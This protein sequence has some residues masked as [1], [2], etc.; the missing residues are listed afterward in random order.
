MLSREYLLVAVIALGKLLSGAELPASVTLTRGALNGIRIGPVAVYADAAGQSAAPEYILFTHARRDAVNA[1]SGAVQ[2]GAAAV[3]PAL[4]RTQFEN[5]SSFWEPFEKARF[6]DYAQPSTKVPVEA[7]RISRA[8]RGGEKLDLKGKQFEVVDTPGYTRGAV[9]YICDVEGKRIAFTGDLIVRDGR[10]PD[11][12]SLQDAI[13]D[14]KARGY[15][16]YAARAGALIASLRRI[17]ALKPDVIVP[18]RGPVIEHP[19][20]AISHLTGRLQQLM[21]SHFS[22]DALLW[23]WGPDNLKV[24]SSSA[25]DGKP[26]DSM[27]MADQQALPAWIIPIAN[28][29]LIVSKTGA[30]FLV[31]AG[32]RDI[33]K[34][35]GELREQGKFRKLEG[36]WITHYHDDH[37]DHVQSVSDHF[38]APVYYTDTM[39]EILRYPGWYRM[40]CLTVAPIK[41]SAQA[42]GRKMQWQE[43]EL[44]FYRFPGQTLYHGG[45]HLRRETGEEIFFVGDSFTPSGIDDY[46]LYNRNIS[47]EG[48]GYLYCLDLLRRFPKTWLINQHVEPMFRFSDAHY[49]RM[50]RELTARMR[51][52]DELSPWPDRNFLV[53]ESWARLYPYGQEVARGEFEVELR[54]MNHSPRAQRFEIKWN[55]PAGMAFISGDQSVQIAGR[56]EGRAKARFRAEESGLHI[57]TIDVSFGDYR[58]PQWTEAM[59]RVR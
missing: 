10:L 48:E 34:R 50:N 1:A 52:L 25:L 39:D 11:L 26:V 3:G 47:R 31:D 4:E 42:D 55:A 20:E 29:R 18:V 27:P 54:L 23:Y 40:P 59:V 38:G 30:A 58:L 17:A 15:H 22:T 57:L 35:L 24:R 2:R 16:G 12:Y 44:G 49:T 13:P 21:A 53:D 37:T 43:F 28:S 45:L 56:T 19:Q 8:V 9:S 6:H 36:I 5:P 14:A 51:L 46:C 7:V 33:L 41:G 32:Y